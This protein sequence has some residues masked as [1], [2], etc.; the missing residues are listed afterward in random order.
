MENR[1]KASNILEEGLPGIGS[2]R[3]AILLGT[4]LYMNENWSE[5]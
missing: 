5:Q 1:D 3:A 4:A 2:H